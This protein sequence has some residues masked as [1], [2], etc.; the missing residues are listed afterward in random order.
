MSPVL[1]VLVVPAPSALRVI[2]SNRLKLVLFHF[3]RCLMGGRQPDEQDVEDTEY[4][5]PIV[6]SLD[7]DLHTVLRRTDARLFIFLAIGLVASQLPA[8]VQVSPIVESVLS[9]IAVASIVGGIGF[10]IHSSV[11][12]KRKVGNRYGV[13]CRACG[14]RPRVNDIVH[15]ADVGLCTR[16]G[17]ELRVRLPSSVRQQR[18]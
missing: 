16:C 13:V 14:F 1:T 3:N 11:K 10:T 18:K 9:V 7:R 5:N 6:A 17:A 2:A 4:E 12:G 8:Y 15:T